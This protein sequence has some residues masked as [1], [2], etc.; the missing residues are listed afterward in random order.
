MFNTNVI[1]PIVVI[2]LFCKVVIFRNEK[3]YVKMG[4]AL[5]LETTKDIFLCIIQML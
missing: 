2:L 4:M 1:S 5:P 3:I